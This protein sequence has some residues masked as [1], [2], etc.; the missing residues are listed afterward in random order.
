MTYAI[1][2]AKGMSTIYPDNNEYVFY[3]DG[4]DG[5][6]DTDRPDSGS[7]ITIGTVTFDGFGI[8]TFKATAGKATATTTADNLVTEFVTTD[9]AGKGTL[10]IGEDDNM[11]KDAEIKIPTQKLTVNV[12]MEHN[13]VYN[14]E[15]Y[16]DMTLAISGGDLAGKV[17]EYKLGDAA[18]T[19]ITKAM[20]GTMVASYQI[21][22]DL[23]KDRIYTV[24]VSGAGYRTSRYEDGTYRPENQITRAEVMTVINKILGRNPSEPYVK[25]LDFNSFSDLEKDKWH[26][27]AALEATITHNYYLDDKGVEIKW[28]DCK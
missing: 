21:K 14:T 17:L 3:Y 5:F 10:K 19:A 27:T 4:K 23:T 12:A 1:K 13:V 26:Y 16:Q 7:K 8:F 25:S 22:T 20:N 6:G 9:E 24:T 15:A 28:E 11:I 18:N 2:T